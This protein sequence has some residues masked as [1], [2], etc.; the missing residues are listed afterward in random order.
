MAGLTLRHSR[1]HLF[2][3]A[4]EGI[5]FGIRQILDLFDESVTRV[6]GTVA[7]GGGVNSPLW[8][9]IVSDVTGRQ[10]IPRE[11]VGACYGGALSAAIGVGLVEAKAIGDLT[12][13]NTNGWPRPVGGD[14]IL[15]VVTP[16]STQVGVAG[17]S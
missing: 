14:L 9:S 7:V 15:R 16:G 4:Y 10:L 1:A 3:A 12:A 11:T 5:A 17:S 8:T 13:D 2:R 6:T